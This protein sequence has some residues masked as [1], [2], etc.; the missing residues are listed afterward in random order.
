MS[1]HFG[2]ISGNQNAIQRLICCV[3]NI[4]FAFG[5]WRWISQD[6][7]YHD[8]NS[9]FLVDKIIGADLIVMRLTNIE[10]G[11]LLVEQAIQQCPPDFQTLFI[12]RVAVVVCAENIDVFVPIV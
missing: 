1:L 8:S 12:Q 9:I 3:G 4:C 5:I 7:V 6:P 2:M 11:S 10:H